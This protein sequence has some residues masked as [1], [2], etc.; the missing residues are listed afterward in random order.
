MQGGLLKIYNWSSPF[1]PSIMSFFHRFT[2][3]NNLRQF[4][5]KYIY[6]KWAVMQIPSLYKVCFIRLGYFIEK[7]WNFRQCLRS[8]YTC[9]FFRVQTECG[10]MWTRITPNRD[11]FYAVTI[12]F[13]HNQFCVKRFINYKW[14]FCCVDVFTIKSLKTSLN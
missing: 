3:D 7:I 4:W 14:L 1:N 12:K 13:V 6:I 8:Q 2:N 9:A 5:N 10:K 11:S